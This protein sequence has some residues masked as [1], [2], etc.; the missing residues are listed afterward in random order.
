MSG[1]QVKSEQFPST[2]PGVRWEPHRCPFRE[3][4]TDRHMEER[5][6]GGLQTLLSPHCPSPSPTCFP[7]NGCSAQVAELK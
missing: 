7:R 4:E 6:E 5:A 2:G 1:R 3:E